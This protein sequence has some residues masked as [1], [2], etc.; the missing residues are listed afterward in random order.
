MRPSDVSRAIDALIPTRRTI[1]LMGPP[2]CAK[3]ELA[4]QAAARRG[5]NFLPIHLV[6][7][8]PEDLK[9]PA[10]DLKSMT[11]HWINSLFP[12]DP[13]WQGI[14][15]LEELG[16]CVPMMQAA[17]MQLI[18]DRRLGDYRVPEGVQF[19]ACSNRREDRA[20]VN[21]FL[22]PL[23]SRTIRI[24][25]DVSN[26][27]W[28]AWA[29]HNEIHMK[30]RTFL[31]FRP[32]L[33]HVFDPANGHMPYPNYRSWKFVSDILAYA[34]EDLLHSLVGGCIGDG[35]AAEA[36]AYWRICDE[37]PDPKLVLDSPK[38]AKVPKEPSVLYA[39]C[40]A[41][42]EMCRTADA[43]RLS[44]VMT[45]AQRLP[46]DFSVLLIRDASSVN[47]KVL[48]TKEAS[49]WLKQHGDVILGSK[50]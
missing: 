48:Y 25:V 10:V 44:S 45:Y 7:H 40:G 27:D 31:Q 11:V 36:V 1:L 4:Q 26:D 14:I 38:T 18:H 6:S 46:A 29:L 3:S 9:F 5:I 35:P 2:G 49:S 22:T 17:S 20:G 39:L 8:Q 24:D 34:P 32:G 47:Q 37:L 15:C 43:A 19:V 12:A 30:V 28:Q 13:E 41:I 23:V 16:Q 50:G 21:A 42:V 33:L